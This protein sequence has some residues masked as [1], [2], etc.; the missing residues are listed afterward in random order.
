M[1]GEPELALREALRTADTAGT[2]RAAPGSQM[3]VALVQVQV[4]RWV[5]WVHWV[6]G[7]CTVRPSCWV[8]QSL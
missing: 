5:H 7:I 2:Q 8:P 6:E 4:L 1:A 3:A